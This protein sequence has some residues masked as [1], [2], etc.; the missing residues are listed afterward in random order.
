MK[1][2]KWSRILALGLCASMAS[3]MAAWAAGPLAQR[4]NSGYDEATWAKLQ[5]NVLE[6]DEI[7][8][9]VHEFN[10]DIVQARK[11][12]ADAE[13]DLRANVEELESQRRK[14]EDLQDAAMRAGDYDDVE[15]YATQKAIMEMYYYKPMNSAL[16]S[17]SGSRSTVA[18][19]QQGEDKLVNAAEKLMIAY[20]SASRQKQ[21]LTQLEQLYAAQYELAANKRAQGMATDADVLAAQVN[22]LSAQSSIRELE[23]GLQQMKP[24]L[25]YLVGWPA[26]GSPEIAPIPA[27]DDSQLDSINLEED[28]RKAIGNNQTLIGQRHSALGRTMDGTA[29]RMA[30]IE[31]GDEKLTI[32]MKRLYDEIFI[33]KTAYEAAQIG[34]QG[35]ELTR[36]KYN[37]MY[38]QGLLGKSD[39][40]G[41]QITYYQKKVAFEGADIALR[42]AINNYRWAVKGYATVSD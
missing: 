26:D 40:L 39:Y 31:E 37:R 42:E 18:T 13:R 23:S 19:M 1:K 38:E 15:H 34:L 29:A 24:T 32:E 4:V 9:L 12:L 5:D 25:C 20:D 28:T 6:Y 21:I 8:L 17:L 14:M 30:M 2:S 16:Q 22:Q 7:P 10:T 3:S 35:A 33:Q 36:D 11:T 27:V 41:A